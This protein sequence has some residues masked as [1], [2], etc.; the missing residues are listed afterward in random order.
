MP[1]TL[2]SP[3]TPLFGGFG[4]FPLSPGTPGRGGNLE[5]TRSVGGHGAHSHSRS[6]SVNTTPGPNPHPT[7]TRG[8][9]FSTNMN[10]SK[11]PAPMLGSELAWSEIQ[12]RCVLLVSFLVVWV[13]E[14]LGIWDRMFGG[15]LCGAQNKMRSRVR[16][17]FGRS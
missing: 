15:G 7:H 9:S 13:L 1:V 14:D 11:S 4:G 17:L 2:S 8:Q 6:Q 5:R 12:S 3:T 10:M 16:L